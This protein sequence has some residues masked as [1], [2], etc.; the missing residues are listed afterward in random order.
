MRLSQ[1]QMDQLREEARPVRHARGFGVEAAAFQHELFHGG[2]KRGA[3][4]WQP[5]TGH[6]LIAGDFQPSQVCRP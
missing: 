2:R 3:K 6:A 4:A 1:F 5:G